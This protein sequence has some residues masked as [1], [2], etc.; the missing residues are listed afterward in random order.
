MV[1]K[2]LFTAS[3]ALLLSSAPSATAYT[4]RPEEPSATPVYTTDM[5]TSLIA[6]QES[7]YSGHL[8]NAFKTIN[9]KFQL[10]SCG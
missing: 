7:D 10:A 1:V 8:T 6:A 4:V 5:V 3:L 2:F 9:G